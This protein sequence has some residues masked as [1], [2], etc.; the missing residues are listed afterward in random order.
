[1]VQPD[2]PV[3]DW[4]ART[5]AKK[6]GWF[7]QVLCTNRHSQIVL[8]SIPAGDELGDER[9]EGAD[10]IFVI[11][12]GDADALVAGRTRPVSARD[13]V[14]VRAGM[15]H[16]IRNIGHA[17]LK[18]FAIY[19]PPAFAEGTIHRTREDAVGAMVARDW[20]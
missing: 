17:D 18:L 16:N 13:V 15:R 2:K 9:Y 5:A 11:V 12:D 8:M 20:A 10:Q 4:N 3:Q 1:M 19:A 6:N 7:R 14:V